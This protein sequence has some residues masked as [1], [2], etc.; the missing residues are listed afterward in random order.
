[1]PTPRKYPTNAARQAAY[2]TR[3]MAGRSDKTPSP[4]LHPGYRR[5][6]RLLRQAEALLTSIVDE[7][8]AYC[9][10]RSEAWQNSERGEELLEQLAAR[11]EIRELLRDQ[12]ADL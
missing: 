6:A 2:R 1:M 8:E 11:E 12:V 10:E 5:W 4:P 3:L 9:A 7:M